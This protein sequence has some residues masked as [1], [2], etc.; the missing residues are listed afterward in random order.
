VND[1]G[2]DQN[3]DITVG[4]IQAAEAGTISFTGAATAGV[5]TIFTLHGA[6]GNTASD[7]GHIDFFSSSTAGAATFVNLG[8]SVAFG[9]ETEFHDSSAAGDAVFTNNGGNAD[10]GFQGETKFDDDSSAGN[11]VITN[12]A[13][14]S[15]LGGFL[16]FFD[17]SSAGNATVTC[18]GSTALGFEGGGGQAT[19]WGS[20]RAGDATFIAQGG[21][22]ALNS[23]AIQFSN[24]STAENATFICN[25]EVTDNVGGGVFFINSSTGGTARIELLGKGTLTVRFRDVHELTIGSIEGNGS[26]AI[27]EN[28]LSVGSNDLST[29]FSGAIDDAGLG[30]SFTKIGRGTLMF[31]SAN[32]YTGGTFV[33][34]GALLVNNTVGSGTGSGSVQVISGHFGGTGI[35]TGPVT[36]GSG[37]SR[38][39]LNP[40]NGGSGSLTILNTLTFGATGTYRWHFDSRSSQA[41]SAMAQG[42]TIT[43]GS[44]FSAH[45]FG[46]V[47]LPVG[48]VFV[49]INNT[50]ATAIDGTFANLADGS[51]ITSGSNNFQ[52]SYEGGDGNDLTLTVVP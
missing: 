36:I 47:Q 6:A 31:S 15:S 19:F 4:T 41:E 2:R 12:K 1:S 18:E 26:V 43:D 40:G 38:A 13:S 29:T 44:L 30:G 10:F 24:T 16:E 28:R 9:G 5:Q 17:T 35:V 42:I 20:S 14:T 25:G 27:M 50:A 49:V 23:G 46:S 51:I 7:A 33:K 37:S 11:A 34:R 48:T 8:S 21:A 45:A 52:A 32:N 3:F 22:G 39:T